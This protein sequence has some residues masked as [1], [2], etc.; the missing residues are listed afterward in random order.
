VKAAVGSDLKVAVRA[1]GFKPSYGCTEGKCGSCELT[2][3]GKTKIRPCV[4]KV[5]N[6]NIVLSE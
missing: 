4:A 6:K 3:D 2:V 5:P 1:S